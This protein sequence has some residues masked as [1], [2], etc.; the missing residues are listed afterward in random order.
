MSLD[1][2]TT[3]IVF[4]LFFMAPIGEAHKRGLASRCMTPEG[5]LAYKKQI[6]NSDKSKPEYANRTG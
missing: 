5:F 6:S 2:A 4:D 1:I 3:R